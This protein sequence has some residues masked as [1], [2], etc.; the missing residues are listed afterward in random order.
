MKKSI[1]LVLVSL[2]CG[3]GAKPQGQHST[4][5][6]DVQPE[7][8]SVLFEE[9]SEIE[10]SLTS[11]DPSL[12]EMDSGL[13]DLDASAQKPPFVGLW[14][15][16]IGKIRFEEDGSFEYKGVDDQCT[17][18][19]YYE[20][21]ENV[22]SL[23]KSSSTCPAD[24]SDRQNDFFKERM[25]I[26]VTFERMLWQHPAL[27]TGVKVWIRPGMFRPE[28]FLLLDEGETKGQDLRM[29]VGQ[30]GRLI[31]GFYFSLLGY[32]SLVSGSGRIERREIE[33]ENPAHLQIR[34]SCQGPCMCAAI[35][36]LVLEGKNITGEYRGIN[37]SQIIGPGSVHG[38]IV[39]WKYF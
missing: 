2:G 10:D 31:V 3:G 16:C 6:T 12:L 35:F 27:D 28:R 34:T 23:Y 32:N 26:T 30:D 11:N 4:D 17:T 13:I 33:A 21:K 9:P 5:S 15:D 22:L 39:D 19:G 37:C 20:L 18:T 14:L 1:I 7:E 29:C 8:I 24:E 36:N 38:S 25:V